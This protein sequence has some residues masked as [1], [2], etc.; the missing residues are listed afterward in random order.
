M[1]RW[2]WRRQCSKGPVICRPYCWPNIVRAI[3]SKRVRW[4][5][6]IARVETGEMRAGVWW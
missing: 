4:A 5:G 3:K 1:E 6:H 2:R